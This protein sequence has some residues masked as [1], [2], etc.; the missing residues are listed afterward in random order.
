LVPFSREAAEVLNES[1]SARLN[2]PAH[3]CAVVAE[4]GEEPPPE[5][6]M[7]T[8]RLQ[9][10]PTYRWCTNVLVETPFDGVERLHGLGDSV[11]VARDGATM[12]IHIH[13]DDPDGVVALLG[14]VSQV[15]VSDMLPPTTAFVLA[16]QGFVDLFASMGVRT[17]SELA[18]FHAGSVLVIAEPQAALVASLAFDARR[19]PPENSAALLDALAR[20]RTASVPAGGELG[21]AVTAL[22][23]GAEL[24][25]IIAGEDAPLDEA[26]VRALVPPGVEVE[27][28]PG[29][30]P[31]WWWLLAAE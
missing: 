19:T 16:E 1:R 4:R 11:M 30:P 14:P 13:T 26:A 3:R 5:P 23:S 25:T 10:P 9:A 21:P 29:A 15:E 20:V 22:A 7:G 24:L 8:P 27:L 31:P 17:V 28:T 18:P 12:R 6:D 2:G